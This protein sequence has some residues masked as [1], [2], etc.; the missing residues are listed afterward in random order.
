MPI[1]PHSWGVRFWLHLGIPSSGVG[2]YVFVCALRLYR[3]NPGWGPWW[4]RLVS[5]YAFTLPI[6]TR[7]LSYVCFCA[8]SA[9]T[10]PILAWGCGACVRVRFLASPRRSW[11]VFVVGVSWFRCC[12]HPADPGCGL[13]V[14]VRV[15]GYGFWLHTAIPDW[16]FRMGVFVCPVCLHPVNPGLGLRCVYSAAGLASPPESWLGFVVC[17]SGFGFC[18]YPTIPCWGVGVCVCL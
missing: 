2:V 5:G 8:R 9:C 13:G 15:F 12:F 16:G 18:F 1:P 17:V 3:A 4:G 7:V 6:L 10:P 11:L 14:W